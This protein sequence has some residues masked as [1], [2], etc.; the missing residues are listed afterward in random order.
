MAAEGASKLGQSNQFTGSSNYPS[1]RALILGYLVGLLS[2]GNQISR[3]AVKRKP[4]YLGI[5]VQLGNINFDDRLL[6][7]RGIIPKKGNNTTFGTF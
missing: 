6:Q 5:G 1:C 2:G 4:E 3:I 7:K